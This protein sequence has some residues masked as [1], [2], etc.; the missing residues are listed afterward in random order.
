MEIG[1]NK[2]PYGNMV[3][4]GLLLFACFI[5]IG[6]V[7]KLNHMPHYKTVDASVAGIMD[8][9][10][11]QESEF[12]VVEKDTLVVMPGEGT[13]LFSTEVSLEEGD[14]LYISFEADN[15][16]DHAPLFHVDLFTPD[17]DFD[18]EEFMCTVD[19]GTAVYKGMLPYYRSAHPNQCLLRIFTLDEA[20]VTIKNLS[21]ER[22]V[23]VDSG[24]TIVRIILYMLVLILALS[25]GW[26]VF[27]FVKWNP[28]NRK[29]GVQK[30]QKYEYRLYLW[31]TFII[32][33]VLMVLYHDAKLTY[34]L[35]YVNGDEMGVYYFVKTIKNFGISLVNPMT[36]GRSGGD[37]FD[38]PF[39]D[40]LSFLLIK[41]ISLF[42][43]HVYLIT[44]LFYFLSYFLNAYSSAFVFRKLGISRQTAV[45]M[46]VLYAFSPYIQLRYAH[47]WLVGYYML[48]LA[49][50]VA[51]HI[52][53]GNVYRQ[54]DTLK[55]NPFFYQAVVISYFCGFTGLYYAYFS[56]ALFAAAFVIKIVNKRCLKQQCYPFAYIL[57]V[58]SGVLTNVM[59]NLLYGILYGKNSAGELTIRNSFDAEVYGMKFV[60]LILPRSGHR[61]PQLASITDRYCSTYPLVNENL[62]A[63]LGIIAS[64][65]FILSLLMLFYGRAKYREISYLNIAVFLIA[66]I[67][68]IGSFI[69]V[70]VKIPMRCYNRMSL[71]IMFLS[72][73]IVGRLFDALK[74]RLSL[75]KF[76]LALLL[77]AAIGLFD[78]TVQFHPP[79]Y[80]E[81]EST[82]NLIAQIQKNMDSGDMIFQLP[83]SNWPSGVTYK[84]HIGYIESDN[85]RWSFG[86]MQGREEGNWQQLVASSQVSS[87]IAQ[88][89]GAGYDGIYVDFALYRNIYGQE[90]AED[91]L[92]SLCNELGK[93]QLKST[94][95]NIYFW[96]I[97]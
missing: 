79:D 88:L 82:R 64:V 7:F 28:L 2:L 53:Q 65:G 76:K 19:P 18:G 90:Q 45:A 96:D 9:M 14:L 75:K 95:G 68:G 41:L 16:S 25:G 74:K 1:K 84:N 55:N 78:Q 72:L 23:V 36:G 24:Y 26:F 77:A 48:P 70:I 12:D 43:D 51:I 63:S 91:Y 27:L 8:F 46:S 11:S 73:L 37:M 40:S 83:Y 69:S 87:M 97:R 80:S 30:E 66:T 38:Y 54:Q 22:Q 15:A 86:A 92:K 31:I 34:P 47:M 10:D 39:S 42:T 49:C 5:L 50:M 52:I 61:I 67:G 21:I 35:V 56:C 20:D 62:T 89:K 4:S 85:L 60:Q 13:K 17:Y 32:L 57:A 3:V 81:F 44:N 29:I 33:A 6:N 71:V 59:P 58:L 93:Q 94:D